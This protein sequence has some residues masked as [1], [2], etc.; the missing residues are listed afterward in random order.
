ML[1]EGTPAEVTV[2]PKKYQSAVI[3]VLQCIDNYY[4]IGSTI[5]HPRFRLNNHKNDSKITSGKSIY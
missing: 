1:G 5:N 4:Y 3:Y 2:A